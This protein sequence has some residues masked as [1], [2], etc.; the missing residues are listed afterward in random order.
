MGKEPQTSPAKKDPVAYNFH[1]QHILTV[2]GST[3]KSQTCIAEKCNK[4]TSYI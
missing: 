4:K 1:S 3:C 2:N